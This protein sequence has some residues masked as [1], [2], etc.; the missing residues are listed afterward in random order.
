[1]LD[2]LDVGGVECALASGHGRRGAGLVR[3]LLAEQAPDQI[4]RSDLELRFLALCREAGLP[5][6]AVN[7]RIEANGT[8]YE[9]DFLWRAH[10]L[11]VETDGCGPHDTR[12]AF[13]SDR[14]PDA[15]LLLAGFRAVRFTW[16]QVEH[17]PADVAATLRAL[18]D[19]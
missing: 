18:L 15:D 6:P 7:T 1:M 13:E 12:A 14:R 17:E 10:Q 2:L 11:I 4:I 19:A 3:R 8:T 16:R 9:V 5:R